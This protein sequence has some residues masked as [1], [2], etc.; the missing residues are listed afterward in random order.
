MSASA[1][2]AVHRHRILA[3]AFTFLGTLLAVFAIFAIWANRQFLNTD[4]Y[5]SSSSQLLEDK[6]IRTA[7]AGF[8]VDQLY[9]NV[10]VQA[11]LQQAFPPRLKPLAAPAAGGLRNLLEQR[12][13]V[14]LQR[15]RVQAAWENANR[16]MHRVALKVI[17]G[18]GTGVSTNNG[19][20]T[21]DVGGLIQQLEQQTGI[22]G[23]VAGKIP[24][25]KAQIVIFRSN[26]LSAI[27]DI[28]SA[29]RPLAILLT[30]LMLAFYAAAIAVAGGWR[31]RMVRA[32]GWGLITAGALVLIGRHFGG[33]AVVS[34]LSKTD[35]SQDAVSA[36]WRI[37]TSLLAEAATATI[38]YGVAAVLGAWLAGP[39]RAGV[40]SRRA[41]APYLRDPAY[42]YGGLAVIVLL[43]LIWG[44]TPGLR[45]FATAVIL[46]GLLA[47]GVEVLRRQTA[48][49]FPDA[50]RRPL[51]DVVRDR[52]AQ[53][54]GGPASGQPA[55][56]GAV[57]Q[58][59]RLADLRDRGVLTQQEFDAEKRDILA[60]H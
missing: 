39:T 60:A 20:V 8:M 14:L 49:E 28:V 42:A 6:H 22:G 7:V 24:P 1:E 5:A 38:L 51:G 57:D 44:P 46:I 33:Q 56:K 30:V 25:G 13:N 35:A 31:R 55:G 29:M 21:L 58:L 48:K 18:G 27:Q 53:L 36:V 19:V 4:N 3:Y 37:E 45:H 23:R 11:Q 15:P 17:N 41:L 47:L 32:A 59:E 43:L 2:P 16:Q 10:N 40:A 54:R 26:Q 9:A 50:V 12:A 52:Y 34:S